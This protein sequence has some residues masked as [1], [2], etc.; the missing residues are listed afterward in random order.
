MALNL[1][2][3]QHSFKRHTIQSALVSCIAISIF[4]T[5]CLFM[6]LLPAHAATADDFVTTWKTDNTGS[7]NNSSIT[8]PTTIGARGY[9]YDVDW[10]N[11][12][13]FDQLGITGDVTHD[14]GIPGTY[15]IR[16]RGD[17]PLIFFNGGGDAQKI[18]NI[19]QWGTGAWS[20]MV[21]A[22][23]GANNLVSTATDAPNLSNVTNVSF[24]F[25]GASAF[26][27]DL[28]GWNTSNVT[29]MGYMFYGASAF[30]S[31]LSGWNTSNVTDMGYMFEN[32]SAFNSDLSGWDMSSVSYLNRMLLFS[33]LSVANYDA[34]L[35][36]WSS[37]SLIPSQFLDA[38]GLKYCTASVARQ[39]IIDNFSWGISDSRSC[40][41][42]LNADN[43]ASLQE[44]L[45]VG[46]NLGVLTV[47]DFTLRANA[48]YTLACAVPGADDSSFVVGGS[49]ED[50]LLAGRVFDHDVPTDAN[51]NNVYDVCVRA[52]NID[53]RSIDQTMQV[54]VTPKKIVTS[55]GFSE[56]NGKKLLTVHGT[57]FLTSIYGSFDAN[58]RSLVALNGTALPMC[59]YGTLITEFESY[60]DD[61]DPQ[62]YN[63]NPPCYFAYDEN[64]DGLMT[65]TQ[66][67]VWLPD[68]FDIAAQGTIVVDG[69]SPYAFNNGAT[70]VTIK[71][72]NKSLNGIPVILKRPTFSG[73]AL[74]GSTVTVTVYSDP[75]A[76]TT[77]TDSNGNWSCTLPSDLEPGEHMVYVTVTNIDS[78][79]SELGPYRVVV[80]EPT[81]SSSQPK[82]ATISGLSPQSEVSITEGTA[83]STDAQPEAPI[84]TTPSDSRRSDD[85]SAPAPQQVSWW[86]SITV[87]LA[88]LGIAGVIFS[89]VRHR[90][91]NKHIQ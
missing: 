66:V 25:Y 73:T 62:Y 12:G 57:G 84:I 31:D 47:T 54:Y 22:F 8:I 56:Q 75:I 53:G 1:A 78:S 90:I 10:D 24:M 33:G 68:G 3:N 41:I 29:D 35:T 5:S 7:S 32:A 82:A 28:S 36:G 60:P 64:Y 21:A 23:A 11:N 40:Y 19:N 4:I 50:Q 2:S 37:Q 26:T 70:P 43:T 13:T 63:A 80:A 88:G 6:F 18:I 15:T 83:A 81:T 76:C 87:G 89:I 30:T 42:K 49:G 14:F 67:Q 74:A 20:T 39:S 72:N 44:S 17:F 59:A 65:A 85:S 71:T 38:R 79:I 46:T 58:F 52:T 86:P 34:L 27:S 69:S 77:T 91:I 9:N 16:I 45:P 48:P 61:Y 51:A 55:V